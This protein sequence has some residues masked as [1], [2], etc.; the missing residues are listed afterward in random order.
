MTNLAGFNVGDDVCTDFCIGVVMDIEEDSVLIEFDTGSGGGSFWCDN[1][2]VAP[3]KPKRQTNYEKL[4]S[5]KKLL[6][7]I[8]GREDPFWR[9]LEDWWCDHK[10]PLK[11]KCQE[12]GDCHDKHSDVEL[13]ELWL[14]EEIEE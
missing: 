14:D 1:S 5:D 11:N 10:C 3:Y 8:L 12:T 4:I 13:A 7:S 9:V 6:A 2:E